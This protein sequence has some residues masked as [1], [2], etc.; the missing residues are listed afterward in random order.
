MWPYHPRMFLSVCSSFAW[1]FTGLDDVLGRLERF[2][3]SASRIAPHTL[4]QLT[5]VA[6]KRKGVSPG[7]DSVWSGR[8]SWRSCGRRISWIVSLWLGK[9]THLGNPV[10]LTAAFAGRMCLSWATEYTR[11]FATSRGRSTFHGISV[12]V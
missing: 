5:P 3:Q 7:E 12:F 8:I 11:S 6:M 4:R 2:Q 10:I 1:L 9:R